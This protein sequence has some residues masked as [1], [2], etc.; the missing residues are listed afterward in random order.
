MP[1]QLNKPVTRKSNAPA[2]TFGPDRGKRLVVTITPNPSGDLL[3]LRP[4]KTQRTETVALSDVY[5]WAI[6]C[7]VNA[8]TMA[9]LREKKAKKAAAKIE[10]AR[11]REIRRPIQEVQS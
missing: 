10:R 3:T 2:A 6:Q 4:E 8:V 1:T 5:R 11:Q 9:K 7:R